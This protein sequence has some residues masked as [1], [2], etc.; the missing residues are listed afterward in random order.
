MSPFTHTHTDVYRLGLHCFLSLSWG[1]AGV[2]RE[3][4]EWWRGLVSSY[5]FFL[6]LFFVFFFA[7]H[8]PNP[9]YI[10]VDLIVAVMSA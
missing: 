5:L 2:L 7:S 4:I 10:V 9:R 1:F 8:R 6:L 3:Y